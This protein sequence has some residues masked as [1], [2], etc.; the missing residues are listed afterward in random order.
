MWD[1]LT[2]RGVDRL[3]P[4]NTDSLHWPVHGGAGRACHE[5]G[6]CLRWSA[7]T[8]IAFALAAAP[9]AAR[10]TSRDF[11]DETLV[12]QHFR[13]REVGVELGLEAR[14]DSNYRVQGWY[15]TELE[16]GLSSRFLIEAQGL[17]A[18]RGQGL[19]LGGWRAGARWRLFD[20]P[21]F[22]LDASL[23]AEYEVETPV[24]KHVLTERIVVPRL[25]LGRTWRDWT[26][27]VNLGVQSRRAPTQLTRFAYS[28]GLRW[29]ETSDI[30]VGIEYMRESLEHS[31]RV[32][33]Q[34]WIAFPGE[35]RLRLGGVFGQHPRPYW[36]VARA[37]LETEF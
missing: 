9:G 1:G 29:P 19:E 24:W 8:T 33:P 32:V 5:S 15:S 26:A 35:A 25:V 31:T 17:L 14:V 30:K 10:G 13:P 6:G 2:K 3:A 16:L 34:L 21:R 4:P 22:P 28:A 12:S 23:A 37:I 11:I 27:T 36:F 7:A 18:S 20:A